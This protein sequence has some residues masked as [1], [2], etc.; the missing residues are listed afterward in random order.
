MSK[1]KKKTFMAHFDKTFRSHL[2][3]FTPQVLHPMK[4]LIKLHNPDKFLQRISFG[5]HFRDLQKL[6]W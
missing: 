2:I 5:S 6:A 1:I 4:D 3:W